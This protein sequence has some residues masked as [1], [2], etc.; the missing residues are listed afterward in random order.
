MTG[1]LIKCC[2]EWRW[3][4]TGTYY[5]AKTIYLPFLPQSGDSFELHPDLDEVDVWR[6]VYSITEQCAYVYLDDEDLLDRGFEKIYQDRLVL[7]GWKLMDVRCL[8]APL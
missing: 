7:A 3:N 8:D 5:W 1:T 6:V 2:F 4:K